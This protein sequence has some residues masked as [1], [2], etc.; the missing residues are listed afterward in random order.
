MIVLYSDFDV[1]HWVDCR[2]TCKYNDSIPRR[3]NWI[4]GY[5]ALFPI[6][7]QA[8][9][10]CDATHSAKIMRLLKYF[11]RNDEMKSEQ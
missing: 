2:S 8:K 7:N 9:R 4:V 10:K 11:I 1:R 5:Y 3:Q 6:C